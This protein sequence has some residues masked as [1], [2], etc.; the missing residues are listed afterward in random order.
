MLR[1]NPDQYEINKK[2]FSS[3]GFETVST[4]NAFWWR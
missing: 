4:K 2:S 1:L 3:Y